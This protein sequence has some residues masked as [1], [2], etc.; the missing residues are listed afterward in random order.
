MEAFKIY[1]RKKYFVAAVLLLGSFACFILS[2]CAGVPRREPISG[3]GNYEVTI[4]VS[5]CHKRFLC[6]G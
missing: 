3:I 6:D 4:G 2:G 1:M 5:Y